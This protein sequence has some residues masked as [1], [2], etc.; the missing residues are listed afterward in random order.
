MLL[1]FEILELIKE[2]LPI[3]FSYASGVLI[4]NK[5]LFDGSE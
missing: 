2:L 4:V 3:Y 1:E 5:Q